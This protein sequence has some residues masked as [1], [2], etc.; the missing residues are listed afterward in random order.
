MAERS[1]VDVLGSAE[2]MRTRRTSRP[3][4]SKTCV[5]AAAIIAPK[6]QS[7]YLDTAGGADMLAKIARW[8][9]LS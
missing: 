2:S 8:E 4:S 6:D 5:R 9:A 1:S 7:A 3:R